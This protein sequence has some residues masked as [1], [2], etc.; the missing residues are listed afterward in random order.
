MSHALQNHIPAGTV[1]CC[2]NEEPTAANHVSAT[3]THVK[4]L[5]TISCNSDQHEVS[6]GAIRQETAK[7]ML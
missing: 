4:W 2:F 1:Q 7:Y 3:P 6:C 5:G